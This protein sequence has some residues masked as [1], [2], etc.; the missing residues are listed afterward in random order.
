VEAAAVWVVAV[1]VVVV[2]VVVEAA[3]WAAECKAL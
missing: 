1:W 3:E 2:W